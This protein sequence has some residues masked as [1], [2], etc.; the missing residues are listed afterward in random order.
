MRRGS[1]RTR[2]GL[3]QGGR[4]ENDAR[5]PAVC[6]LDGTLADTGH[7]QHF[8]AGARRD[9]ARRDDDRR[10]ARHTKLEILKRLG[11]EREL[12]VL[13]DERRAGL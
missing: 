3:L 4:R 2:A 10:P 11:R 7:R 6:D 5:P 8:Q 9:R 1:G 13:V 12:R